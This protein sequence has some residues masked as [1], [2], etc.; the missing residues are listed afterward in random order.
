VPFLLGK[1]ISTI[2]FL[3]ASFIENV[4]LVGFPSIKTGLRQWLLDIFLFFVASQ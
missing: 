4:F 2:G 3:S 1:G